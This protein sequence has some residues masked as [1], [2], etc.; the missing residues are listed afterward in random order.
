MDAK[1]K[2]QKLAERDG[3][4][5]RLCGGDVTKEFQQLMYW[6]ARRGADPKGAAELKRIYT[7]KDGVEN[8]H[9]RSIN[10]NL[11]HVVPKSRGGS[12]N[13]N[14]LV[15]AHK[16]CN[17]SKGNRL[18]VPLVPAVPLLMQ[19]LVA[20]DYAPLSP[21]KAVKSS[22]SPFRAPVVGTVQTNHKAPPRKS[23]LYLWRKQVGRLKLAYRSHVA[24]SEFGRGDEVRPA[25]PKTSVLPLQHTPWR[26][27]RGVLR[28]DAE[29]NREQKNGSARF[30]KTPKQTRRNKGI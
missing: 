5:C 19:P 4:I 3:V 21:Q 17:S 22:P 13:L 1:K 9:R 18:D 16:K 20:S 2:V 29:R 15:L 24:K 8:K 26:Q 27:W 12:D 30:A 10:L 14:N 11:D 6:F 28:E 23:L 25:H 7:G